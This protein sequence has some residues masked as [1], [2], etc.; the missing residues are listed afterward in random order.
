MNFRNKSEEIDLTIDIAPL[1]DI[2]FI[3]LIFF[4]VSTTFSQ[5]PTVKI[6]LPSAN[7]EI[8]PIDEKDIVLIVHKNNRYSINGKRNIDEKILSKILIENGNKSLNIEADKGIEYNAII[9]AIDIAHNSKIEQ[10]NFI[11]ESPQK[12]H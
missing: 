6:N 5:K 3:L 12:K 4:M 2:V 8:E 11:V 1:I 9:K 10:I 7:A